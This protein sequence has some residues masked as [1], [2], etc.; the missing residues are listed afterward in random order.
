MCAGIKGGV[1]RPEIE[2][3]GGRFKFKTGQHIYFE[4]K[5]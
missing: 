4:R 3:Y 5:A 2:N 1:A